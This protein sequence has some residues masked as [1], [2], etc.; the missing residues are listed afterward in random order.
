MDKNAGF[1]VRYVSSF[2]KNGGSIPHGESIDK[3]LGKFPY[4]TKM[5][6]EMILQAV[7]GLFSSGVHVF[8]LLPKGVGIYS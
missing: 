7:T 4:S 5:I 2:T 8:F 3:S 6:P 1:P